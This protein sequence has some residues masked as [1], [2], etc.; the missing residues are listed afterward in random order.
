MM[1]GFFQKTT[2]KIPYFLYQSLTRKT[3]ENTSNVLILRYPLI[4]AN[5][6]HKIAVH[7]V[8]VFGKHF[9]VHNVE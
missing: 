4:K 2:K 8:I 5:A 9:S 3:F 1:K 7:L 6:L